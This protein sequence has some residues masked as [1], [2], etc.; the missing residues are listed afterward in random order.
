[1]NVIFATDD[2]YNKNK[3]KFKRKIYLTFSKK[4][5]KLVLERLL[6]TVRIAKS[7]KLN[8]VFSSKLNLVSN[9]KEAVDNLVNE[10]AKYNFIVSFY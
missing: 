2:S 5:D 1:M 9:N 4:L 3:Y 10:L 8:E 6:G 7:T